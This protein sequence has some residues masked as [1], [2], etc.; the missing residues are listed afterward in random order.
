MN[1]PHNL[2]LAR[3]AKS[4]G[5]KNK[6]SQAKMA[7]DL[8]LTRSMVASY[9]QGIAEPCLCTLVKMAEYFDVDVKELLK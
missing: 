9:E 7:N 8:G 3:S 2:K 6:I 5:L 1:F 4:I